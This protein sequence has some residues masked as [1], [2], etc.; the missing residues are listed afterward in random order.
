[1]KLALATNAGKEPEENE[2][3]YKKNTLL[4]LFS[5]LC[6][7]VCLFSFSS[8][9]EQGQGCSRG[10][11]SP[12]L[13]SCCQIPSPRNCTSISSWKSMPP[14]W[15]AQQRVP[16]SPQSMGDSRAAREGGGHG[17]VVEFLSEA[18]C[19]RLHSG[20]GDEAGVGRGSAAW[21]V[22][23]GQ[24]QN[25]SQAAVISIHIGLLCFKTWNTTGV[26]PQSVSLPF[27]I[28]ELFLRSF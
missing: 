2:L 15:T 24:E 1:M 26:R 11:S 5:F 20:E 10:T 17:W 21:W 19:C 16:T 12:C 22:Q 18:R 14:Q 4:L 23:W 3:S 13:Y 28:P 6:L 8:L 9:V 7:F 25:K 27:S